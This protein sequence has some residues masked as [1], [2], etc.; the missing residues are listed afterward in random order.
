MPQTSQSEW[1][2]ELESV[3]RYQ[4]KDEATFV[5]GDKTKE[6]DD[7][8]STSHPQ[9]VYLDYKS[10]NL[11]F[12]DAIKWMKIEKDAAIFKYTIKVASGQIL[13]ENARRYIV[14]T[15]YHLAHP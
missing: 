1:I 14:N 8:N 9:G 12:D 4:R 11:Y 10:V 15:M 7:E 3:W 5:N 6:E 13:S 2:R